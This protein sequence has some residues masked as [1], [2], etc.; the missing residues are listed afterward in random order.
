[1]VDVSDAYAVVVPPE[2]GVQWATLS[3]RDHDRLN[4]RLNR[5]ARS[6]ALFPVAW[7]KGEVGIHRGKHRA[8][9]EE[10][11]LLYRLD[12]QTRTVDVIGFGRVERA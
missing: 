12:D 8:I 11:W 7:P 2:L 9:V 3:S 4:E 5:A 10:L 1:M 6:A